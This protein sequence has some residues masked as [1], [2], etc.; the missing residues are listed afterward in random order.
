M[1][2]DR[3]VAIAYYPAM[4]QLLHLKEGGE[5]LVSDDGEC[6]VTRPAVGPLSRGK[7]SLELN[8]IFGPAVHSSGNPRRALDRGE[9]AP[10]KASIAKLFASEMATQVGLKAIQIHGGYG[11]TKDMP[12]ERYMRDA[13]LMEIGEGSSEVQRIIIARQLLAD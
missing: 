7:R 3:P 4:A 1:L 12:V 8:L 10:L 5:R 13:K 9:E 2:R 6:Q 11:Y